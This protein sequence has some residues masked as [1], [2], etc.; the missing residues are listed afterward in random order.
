MPKQ[1]RTEYKVYKFVCK[2]PGNST[3]YISKKLDMSG[4]RVRHALCKLK[5]IGLIRFKFVRDNPRIR[6]LSY[7]VGML[8]LLPRGMK[9]Q[10]KKLK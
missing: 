4:G 8:K 6:K 9:R 3:Y 1:N 5:K 10:L 2:N 7:P